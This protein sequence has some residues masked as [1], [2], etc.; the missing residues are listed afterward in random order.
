V[1]GWWQVLVQACQALV[2]VWPAL[3]QLWLALVPECLALVQASMGQP[4]QPKVLPC[5]L[6]L[7]H[8]SAYFQPPVPTY[9][10]LPAL[11]QHLQIL[12]DLLGWLCWF[13]NH[14]RGNSWRLNYQREEST[15][16]TI[17]AHSQ[18]L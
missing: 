11:S 18:S 14:L 1:L 2:Q 4:G 8:R 17:G 3:A 7:E 6:R 12:S 13:L 9:T 10:I 15:Q 5:R 16:S